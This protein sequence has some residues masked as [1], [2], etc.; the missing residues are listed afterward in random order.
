MAIFLKKF[1]GSYG[2]SNFIAAR[3]LL[4]P[5]RY[6]MTAPKPIADQSVSK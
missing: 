4:S 3:D 6:I 5:A 1:I 2:I